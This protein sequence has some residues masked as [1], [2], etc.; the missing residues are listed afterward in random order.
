MTS[1][2]RLGFS[3]LVLGTL[4]AALI[5]FAPAVAYAHGRLKSSAPGSGAHLSLIPRE[6]RL[7]FSEVP[8]LT[9]ST[10]A[11]LDN[12]GKPVGSTS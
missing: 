6:L 2:P 1:I 10:V 12:T 3:R 9:F 5:L 8:D 4:L 11:L 7:E